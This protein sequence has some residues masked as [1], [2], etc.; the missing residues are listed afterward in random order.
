MPNREYYRHTTPSIYQLFFP[1]MKIS[2]RNGEIKLLIIGLKGIGH[3]PSAN[4]FAIKKM[5]S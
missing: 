1:S 4:F 3:S 2:N 5:F